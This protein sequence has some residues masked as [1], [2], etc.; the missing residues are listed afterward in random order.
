[1]EFFNYGA[2]WLALVLSLIALWISGRRNTRSDFRA[3]VIEAIQDLDDVIK[4]IEEYRAGGVS[5]N[6]EQLNAL[7]LASRQKREA[8]KLRN[9]GK[10]QRALTAAGEGLGTL[11]ESFPSAQ[12]PAAIYRPHVEWWRRGS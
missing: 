10:Y 8:R 5:L 9:E 2:G 4:A 11:E 1:M 3:R 6:S 12:F 7:I